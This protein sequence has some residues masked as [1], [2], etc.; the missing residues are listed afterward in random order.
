MRAGAYKPLKLKTG[1]SVDFFAT[2]NEDY[3]WKAKAALDGAR[4]PTL[5]AGKFPH[6]FPRQIFAEGNGS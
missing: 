5:A 1:G 6:G 4:R 3:F 2:P